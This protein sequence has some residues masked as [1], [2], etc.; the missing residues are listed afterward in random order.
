MRKKGNEEKLAIENCKQKKLKKN[1]EKEKIKERQIRRVNLINIYDKL[2][3]NRS[4]MHKKDIDDLLNFYTFGI[5]A[6][7]SFA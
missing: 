2:L 3:R 1:W 7:K 5:C 6:H 4:Q